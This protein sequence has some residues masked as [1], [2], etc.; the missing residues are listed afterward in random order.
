MDLENHLWPVAQLEKTSVAYCIGLI[1]K[2]PGSTFCS[3]WLRTGK[4][5]PSFVKKQILAVRSL[6]VSPNTGLRNVTCKL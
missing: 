6:F 5:L 1:G 2:T 3:D 4:C